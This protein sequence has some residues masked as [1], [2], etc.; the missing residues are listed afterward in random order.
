MPDVVARTTARRS[1]STVSKAMPAVAGSR[2]LGGVAR[3]TSGSGGLTGYGQVTVPDATNQALAD[4]GMQT[5]GPFSPGRPIQ[6][7]A[8][9]GMD[10]RTWDFPTG[11][12]V[13]TKPRAGTGRV[14]FETLEAFIKAWDVLRL[15][16]NHV[17]RDI[18]SLDWSIV[19]MAGLEEDV[20]DQVKAATKIMAKPDGATP[21]DSWQWKF[22]EDVLRYDAGTL[23]RQRNRAGEVRALE[24]VTGT[25]VAPLVDYYGREPTGD[26]PAYVQYISGIPW[27]WLRND[28]LIYLPFAPQPESVYGLPVAEWLMLTG[29][30]D[31]RFQW[32]FLLYFTEGTLPDTFMEAPPDQSSPEEL[33]K[34]QNAWDT[35]MEGDQGQKHKVRWV[36]SG[37]KPTAAGNKNFD[38]QFPLYLIRKTCAAV[39][40]TPNDIGITDAVNKASADTQ[41]DVQFRIGTQPMINHLAGI[42]SRYLQE[43]RG[44]PVEFQ[45]DD[46]REKEDRLQEAQAWDFYVRMGAASPDEPRQ[47]VLGLPIDRENPTPR[48]VVDRTGI[49]PLIQLVADSGE[50]DPAT[51]APVPERVSAV[52]GDGDIVA[53]TIEA[54]PPPPAAAGTPSGPPGQTPEPVTG[55]RAEIGKPPAPVAKAAGP[56]AAGLAV[57]AADTGRVLMLQ[58]ALSDDDPA[59]GTWEF[60]GGH[61]EDGEAPLAAA[62]REWGEETGARLP[63]GRV[64]AQWTSP[65]GAYQGY[66]YVIPRE[67]DLEINLDHDDRSVL[68]PDDPDGDDIEVAAWWDP[69]HAHA[70]PG[71]RPECSSTDWAALATAQLEPVAKSARWQKRQRARERREVAAAGLPFVKAADRPPLESRPIHRWLT[72]AEEWLAAFVARILGRSADPQQVAQAG[73]VAGLKLDLSELVNALH[74]A[75]GD[76]W[77]LGVGGAQ[78]L[79]RQ[80]GHPVAEGQGLYRTA[81]TLNWSAWRP[82]NA[83][84]ARQLAGE[85]GG[86]GLAKLLDQADIVIQGI[87]DD[88][89]KRLGQVLAQSAEAGDSVDTTAKAVRDV[90]DDPGR[91][92]MIAHTELARAV[93]AASLDTYERNGIPGK[94]WLTYH[95][96]PICEANEEAGVIPLDQDFPSGDAAPPAHPRC[97]CTIMPEQLKES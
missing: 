85:E 51:I 9:W 39:G 62:I 84:A 1:W 71:L 37:A 69:A 6:Q 91:A 4:Q 56:V 16:I 77:L 68:N 79:V 12:N 8:P 48:F 19:P 20:S 53:R 75:Y 70:M 73:T 88:T 21:F 46:G 33:I 41:V 24:V 32:H 63:Q 95:P 14:S 11:Y 83:E 26:A 50:I 17:Q 49:H 31:V 86:D 55:D 80:A 76:G 42:Y 2:E 58:R 72:A 89:L 57:K 44:L 60:P 29:N 78:E 10:P 22:L 43:D 61:V 82:G 94:S 59:A 81:A 7:F 96:C 3:L 27:Q 97:R 5:G 25:S 28:A 66:V 64:A 52:H 90:L 30:T 38:P 92:Q 93:G 87:S 36:P 74:A 15:C 23:Y 40:I 18:R 34:F 47:Q 67:A 35:F 54:P 45:F 65:N 13:S